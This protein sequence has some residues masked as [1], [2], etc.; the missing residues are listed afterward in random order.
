LRESGAVDALGPL[1]ILRGKWRPNKLVNE[2]DYSSFPFGLEE[3]SRNDDRVEEDRGEGDALC[4]FTLNALLIVR[5]KK[6]LQKSVEKSN[7][8]IFSALTPGVPLDGNSAALH[9]RSK[10]TIVKQGS[11]KRK[12]HQIIQKDHIS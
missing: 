11:K 12:N 3:I 9:C 8:K 10:L 5:T 4:I 7:V 6:G 1:L 2:R